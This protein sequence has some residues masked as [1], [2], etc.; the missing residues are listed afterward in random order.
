MM[1]IYHLRGKELKEIRGRGS[2]RNTGGINEPWIHMERPL[3]RCTA[4]RSAIPRRRAHQ[5]R[6]SIINR[7]YEGMNE[8]KEGWGIRCGTNGDWH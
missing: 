1:R 5:L 6:A 4:L 3:M 8:M 2:V 7:L